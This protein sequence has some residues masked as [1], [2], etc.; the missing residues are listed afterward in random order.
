MNRHQLLRSLHETIEPRTYLETGV[1]RGASMALSRVPSIGVDPEF[2]VVF[3]AAGRR[4]PGPHDQRR[5]LRPARVRSPTSRS[6]SW[7]L[8]FVDGMRLAE[9]AL[10]DF[11]ADRA[12]HPPDDV[13]VIDD[14]LRGRG[15]G[16]PPAHHPRLDRGRL[17]G[18]RRAAPAPA[19]PAWCST[20][21]PTPPGPTWCSLRTRA[22]EGSSRVDESSRPRP[23]VPTRDPCPRPCW[24]GRRRSTPTCCWRILRLAPAGR[25]APGPRDRVVTRT[26]GRRSATSSR[27]G[28]ARVG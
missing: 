11:L 28:A 7:D 10:R 14:M 9:Y 2:R 20:W 8:A 21:T 5:V 3:G 18:R 22:A 19:R 13:V 6:R 27:A 1:N 23:C 16:Q 15:D 4:P 26:S 17:Q 24:S 25:P 12:P